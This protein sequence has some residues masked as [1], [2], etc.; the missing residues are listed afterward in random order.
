MVDS[1]IEIFASVYLRKLPKIFAHNENK[2][3]HQARKYIPYLRGLQRFATEDRTK[4]CT[5]GWQPF[6]T[7]W[8]LWTSWCGSLV[9]GTA[10]MGNIRGVSVQIQSNLNKSFSHS[11]WRCW[12]L[13][14]SK[15]SPPHCIH[16]SQ[17][18]FQ[19]WKHSWNSCFGILR[20][21]ASEFSLISSTR[22]KS[23]S[24]QDGYQHDEEKEIHWSK[25]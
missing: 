20:S 21:S 17:R 15:Y 25:V 11:I 3:V 23:S 14:P 18:F 16:R 13:S 22:L 9:W 19:F 12:A 24:C 1:A 10:I 6:G 5:R 2:F 4:I 7:Y 8:P